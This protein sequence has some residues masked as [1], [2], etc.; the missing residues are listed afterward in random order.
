M[1][2]KILIQADALLYSGISILPVLDN[3]RP[4]LPSWTVLQSTPM[5]NEQAENLFKTAWGIGVICG[6]V[7]ECL[8]CI[9]FDAHGKDIDK[10]FNDYT[11]IQGVKDI[12]E[13]N[14]VYIEQSPSG[15]IHLI[16]RYEVD[17]KPQGSL[18]LA[19][20]EDGTSMIETRGEGSYVIIAPT[21]GYVA[22]HGDMLNISQITAEERD[23]LLFTARKFNEGTVAAVNDPGQEDIKA[24]DHTDPVSFFNWNCAAYAKNLLKDKGWNFVSLDEKTGIE[25]WR[26]PGKTDGISATWG[27]KHNA[28]YLFTTSVDYFKNECYYTPFQ[29]LVRLRFKDDFNSAIRWVLDKYFDED[30]KYIRVG[31]DY[32]KKINKT[33]RFGILRMELKPW[34]K[35]E[36]KM[37]E[38]KKLLENI[39]KYD[40]FAIVPNNRDYEPVIQ[41]CYNLYHEFAHRPIEGKW[42]WTEILLSHIFGEQLHL[43]IRYLQALYLHP[44]RMLP[45]LVLVSK[46]RQTG[47][48]TFINWLNMVFG[49]NMV[50]INPEDLVG[51]FNSAYANSN[52]IAVEETLIEKT[53]TVEKLKAL[54]TGKMIT[55]NQKFISQYSLPFYGKIILASNNEDKFARIDEEEIRFFIRKVGMPTVINHNI[56]ADMVNEIPAFLY[57]LTTLPAIDWSRD[58]SGFTPDEILNESLKNVKR[59]SKSGLYK[60]LFELFKDRFMQLNSDI[61]YNNTYKSE[62]ITK[63]YAAP[64]DIKNRWFDKNSRIDIQYIKSVLK[65]EFMKLPERP[66]RYTPLMDSDSKTGT[67]YEFRAE[68]FGIDFNT[69]KGHIEQSN[70]FVKEI[71]PPF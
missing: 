43:G 16:Y 23:F 63:I 11:N 25:S 71:E 3:K 27:K 6:R 21:P 20:W 57:H 54:A 39:P 35:D 68:D 7:S 47:K 24:Y 36:I 5:E 41:N 69:I 66:M 2:N 45:I 51:S 17:G 1:G 70:D 55:V 40:D 34:K 64:I 62:F 48:T 37:D 59:E 4:A 53:V 46:E 14:N 15:G 44:D 49:A 19:N 61:L 8:E 22:Q 60:D 65:N 33:D 42:Y 50:N 52:I 12:I 29:I 10:I 38:G 58:R 13:R 30:I 32:F 9:D 18:K 26:R 67:P 56:E 31:T 28:L